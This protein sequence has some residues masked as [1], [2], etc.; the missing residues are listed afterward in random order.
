MVDEAALPSGAELAQVAARQSVDQAGEHS[1]QE[2]RGGQEQDGQAHDEGEADIH[3]GQDEIL[4]AQV[5]K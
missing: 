1:Q 4:D 5:E 2:Q 3:R